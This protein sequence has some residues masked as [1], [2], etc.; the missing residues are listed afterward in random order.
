MKYG[1]Y[2]QGKDEVT[3]VSTTVDIVDAKDRANL[4]HFDEGVE[5][6]VVILGPNTPD[7]IRHFDP[8]FPRTVFRTERL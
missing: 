5:A 3:L 4:V 6:L 7:R 1:I 8:F 2:K